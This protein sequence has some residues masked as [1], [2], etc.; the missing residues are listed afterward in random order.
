MTSPNQTKRRTLVLLERAGK[1]HDAPVWRVASKLLGG[2][3]RTRVEVNLGRISRLSEDG[4]VVLVPGKV[5][6][7]GVID[8]KVTV[9]AYSFSASAKSKIAAAGG[10][11]LSIQQFVEKFPDGSGVHLVK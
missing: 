4:Q 9:G 7:S 10:S 2:T 1:E 5:L 11:A 8:K 6:G 3:E